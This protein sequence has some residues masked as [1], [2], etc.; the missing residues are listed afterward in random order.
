MQ[1]SNKLKLF[2]DIASG[3]G[4][5]VPV[6]QTNEHIVR[7]TIFVCDLCAAFLST[8]WHT[9]LLSG[10]LFVL[11]VSYTPQ[12]AQKHCSAIQLIVLISNA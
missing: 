7:D 5:R 1:K 4:A 11:S 12:K 9:C 6:H 3:H 8:E 10:F 2:T